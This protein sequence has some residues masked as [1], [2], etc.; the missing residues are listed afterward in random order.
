[1]K[2]TTWMGPLENIA[3][4]FHEHNNA[5]KANSVEISYNSLF[6]FGCCDP[7]TV[8]NNL[9]GEE[10]A[11]TAVASVF[12]FRQNHQTSQS[13]SLVWLNCIP[14]I[15]HKESHCGDWLYC[16]IYSCIPGRLDSYTEYRQAHARR[17]MPLSLCDLCMADKGDYEAMYYHKLIY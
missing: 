16:C 3:S 6:L 11:I 12:F 13:Y 10:V 8:C 5:D 2:C 1:M 14:D 7:Y 4:K 15:F 17:C 9:E